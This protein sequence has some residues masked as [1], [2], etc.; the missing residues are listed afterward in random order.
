VS[1]KTPSTYFCKKS[2]SKAFPK[3]IGKNFDV[4]FSSTF[5]CFIAFSGVSQRWEFKNTQKTF[6]K[7]HRV[8]KF[9]KS[10]TKNPKPIF[11]RFVLSRFLA[12][13]G[14]GSSKT[15]KKI[16]EKINLTPALFCTLTRPSTTALKTYGGRGRGARVRVRVRVRRLCYFVVH[17]WCFWRPHP[18][19]AP[20]PR[21]SAL[22][23]GLEGPRGPR[24]RGTQIF[25]TGLG[26]VGWFLRAQKSTR[27]G[28]IFCEIFLSCF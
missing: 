19:P 5:F 1:S 23:G 15:R 11:S 4:R 25:L 8:E 22:D 28:Q 9:T 27:A 16:S 7:K 6:Y 10:S 14:E 17:F 13:L 21:R 24:P 26:V 20:R 12:F 3:K 2:R 18:A